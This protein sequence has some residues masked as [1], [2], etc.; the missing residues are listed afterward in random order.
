MPFDLTTARKATPSGF[1]VSTARVPGSP[2]SPP[3]TRPRAEVEAELRQ[4]LADS[5]T[6]D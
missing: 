2:K 6:A 4:R 3:E 1:D 5:E